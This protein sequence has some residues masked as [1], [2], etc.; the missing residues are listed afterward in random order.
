MDERPPDDEEESYQSSS[1]KRKESKVDHTYSDYSQHQI[2]AD[3]AEEEASQGR[4]RQ[5]TFPAKL[6][7]IV[8]NPEYRVS[9]R[10]QTVTISR[11]RCGMGVRC[12]LLL[13]HLSA[14]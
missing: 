14:Y 4:G 1:K 13:P 11:T 10:R 7:E 3:A 9:D 6:H 12:I 2:T 5:P 8:S